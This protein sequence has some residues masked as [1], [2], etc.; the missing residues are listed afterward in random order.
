M[1]TLLLG[2]S[3]WGSSHTSLFM[4]L[5]LDLVAVVV[6]CCCLM[7]SVK[8]GGP[9]GFVNVLVFLKPLRPTPQMGSFL[10]GRLL[11]FVAQCKAR[12]GG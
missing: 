4:K 5:D 7:F 1:V 12:D 9:R 8:S 10:R 11:R 6:D 3:C 2:H